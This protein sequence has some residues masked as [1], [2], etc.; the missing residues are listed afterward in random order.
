MAVDEDPLK[1]LVDAFVYAPLGLLALA[2]AEFPR[3]VATG[4]ANFE[5]QAAAARFV[6][7]MAVEAGRREVRDWASRLGERQAGAPAAPRPAAPPQPAP[8]PA[9][10][11]APAEAAGSSAADLPIEAYDSLAASQVVGRLASLTDA[12]LD[13]VAAYE[14]AHR[15]RRTILGKIAQL[16]SR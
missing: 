8:A 3:L 7:R 16:Q 1:P 4:R 13:A 5:Q 15:G 2:R 14:A 12:E 6:G 10:T 9:A 11:A